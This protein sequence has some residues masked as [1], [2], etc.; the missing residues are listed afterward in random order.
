MIQ[1]IRVEGPDY[2]L[3][4]YTDPETGDAVKYHDLDDSD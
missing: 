3:F 2:E 4:N 1:G